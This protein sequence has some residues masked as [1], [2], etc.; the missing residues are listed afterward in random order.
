MENYKYEYIFKNSKNADELFDAFDSALK[1]GIDDLELYKLLF[2][3]PA[4]SIDMLSMFIKKLASTFPHLAYDVYMWGAK[5][6]ELSFDN[7]ENYETILNFYK[8]ASEL[9]PLENEPY[10]KA[11]DAYNF[12][13]KVH[14]PAMVINFL[15]KGITKVKDPTTLYFKLSEFFGKLGNIELKNHYLAEGE[16][17]LR[18][19]YRSDF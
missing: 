8:K 7:V 15:K 1:E 11:A 14:S 6:I 3:N 5:V 19:K 16:K 4:L 17:H 10:V 18:R 9:K 2:W 13:L 12:D